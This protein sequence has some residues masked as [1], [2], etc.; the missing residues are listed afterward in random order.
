MAFALVFSSTLAAGAIDTA[1]RPQPS[2]AVASPPLPTVS[3]AATATISFAATAST[4]PLSNSVDY[5][6]E[7][8]NGTSAVLVSVCDTYVTAAYPKLWRMVSVCVPDA[9][10]D[11]RTGSF[12][13][14]PLKRF[15]LPFSPFK[16]KKVREYLRHFSRIRSCW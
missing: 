2:T 13:T 1:A 7:W 5:T 14:P 10:T 9:V 8:D 11:L 12:H 6:A 16:D 3:A 15:M 4:V